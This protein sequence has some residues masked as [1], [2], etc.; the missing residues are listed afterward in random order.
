MEPDGEYLYRWEYNENGF[1]TKGIFAESGGCPEMYWNW[2][3][4][5]KLIKSFNRYGNH[6]SG[7]EYEYD[8]EGNLSSVRYE[9]HA[10]MGVEVIMN[11]K[12]EIIE[13]DKWGN[14]LKRNLTQ[15]MNEG[16]DCIGDDTIPHD[17][18]KIVDYGEYKRFEKR[19]TTF[20]TETRKIYYH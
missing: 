1:P 7:S 10:N 14:W 9:E 11:T 17:G 5:G 4:D 3:S 12:V 16:Y 2:N 15:E 6:G 19:D 8:S 20:V 18:Y 13:T